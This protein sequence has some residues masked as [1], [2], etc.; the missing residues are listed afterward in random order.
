MTS[1]I[2]LV[3]A[4]K[5]LIVSMDKGGFLQSRRAACYLKKQVISISRIRN[6][7]WFLFQN[8]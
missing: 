1:H 3:T 6:R 8:S 5:L 7:F 2:T 4:D